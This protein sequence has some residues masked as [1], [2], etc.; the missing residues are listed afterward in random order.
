MAAHHLVTDRFNDIVE[1]EVS[2]FSCHLCVEDDLHQQ[3]AQLVTQILQVMTLNRVHDF[4]G[5]FNR[6]GRNGFIILL[7][8]P[9]TTAIRI[10]QIIH[11]LQKR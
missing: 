1:I 5:L 11:D 7:H 4:I 2:S 10:S 3:V 9:R 6:V 8:I